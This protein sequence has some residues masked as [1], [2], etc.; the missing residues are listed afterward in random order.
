MFFSF[1]RMALGLL[2]A[3]IGVRECRADAASDQAY[4]AGV[5]AYSAAD[6]QGAVRQAEAA[7]AADPQNWQAWQ[8]DGNARYALGDTAG[9]LTVYQYSLQAH[10]DNPELRAMVDRL[11]AQAVAPAATPPVTPPA[12]ARPARV[13]EVQ[14]MEA[15][16]SAPIRE[17]KRTTL[18]AELG[19]RNIA[20]SVELGRNFSPDFAGSFSYGRGGYADSSDSYSASLFTFALTWYARR[21]AWS[22][23]ATFGLNIFSVTNTSTYVTY[24]YT[25]GGPYGSYYGT[26]TTRTETTTIPGAFFHAGAGMEYRGEAGFIFRLAMYDIEFFLWPGLSFGFSF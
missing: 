2:A 5:A 19:G 8:L 1:A 14:S 10:P 11:K 12:A 21:S 17:L 7:V 22:P 6:Y 20:G 13:I 15:S 26:P 24:T 16:E 4:A 18:V 9:A 25:S 23:Y 3:V